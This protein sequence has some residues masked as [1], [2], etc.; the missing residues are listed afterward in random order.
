MEPQTA[1]EAPRFAT[2]SFPNSFEPHTYTPNLLRVEDRLDGATMADLLGRGHQVE[3]WP[4]WT[5]WAGVLCGILVEPDGQRLNG[6]ADPRK[7]AYAV[8]R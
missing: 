1:V 5:P 4:A 2:F 7:M 6:A 3:P 8:G